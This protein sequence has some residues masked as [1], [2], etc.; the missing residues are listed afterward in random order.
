M[1]RFE[2]PRERERKSTRAPRDSYSNRE[3][4]SR[5]S[6]DDGPRERRYSDRDS[7]RTSSRNRRD[8]E[9][10]KVTCSSCGSRCEVPFKPVSNK[11]VY[12]SECF[13]KKEKFGSD[14]PPPSTRDFDMINEKL[15][16]IIKML[17]SSRPDRK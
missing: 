7:P 16:K 9:M 3:S 15:N 14:T 4:R 2:R 8:Y 17:E 13:S 12:C 11:P 6:F 1:A 10:T 5:P